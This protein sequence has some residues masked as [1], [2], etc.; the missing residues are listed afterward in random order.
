MMRFVLAAA[1]VILSSFGAV[2]GPLSLEGNF[3]QG[4]LVFG[5]TA[6]DAEVLFEGKAVRVSPEGHFVVGFGRDFKETAALQIRVPGQPVLERTLQ[7]ARRTYATEK[8]DGLPPSKV[9]PSQKFLD[10]IRR[11]N[12]EIARIR[13]MDTDQEWFLSGWDWPAEGRISGVYGSQRILNGIP[14]RPH[15]G[16]DVAAPVGTPVYT[17]TD[18]VVRMTEPDL[19]YTGGTIM[20]DHGHGLVSVYSH[21]ER[22]HVKVGDFVKKGTLIGE[23]G[24]TGRASGPHLDWRLNWF[25]ERLDPQLLVGAKPD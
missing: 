18:G 23:I 5:K 15:F 7:V 24:A 8:V 14:K 19:Y 1:L 9:T 2:A 25:G 10:R 16:L 13:A 20:I 3:V 12:A 11:E 4:G 21:L 17:S 22:L 6:P